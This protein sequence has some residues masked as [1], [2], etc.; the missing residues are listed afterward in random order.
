MPD[1]VILLHGLWLRAFTL[2]RLAQTLR[3]GGYAVEGF[4]YHSLSEAPACAVEKLA[5]RIGQTRGPVHLVGHSLGG[6]I[7]LSALGQHALPVPRAVCLGS[8]LC[9]SLVARRIGT[10]RGLRGVLGRARRLLAEGLERWEGATEVGVV[11][12]SRSLGF[13]VL[14]GR[15]QRPHDGTVAVA[16]TRLPG[17]RD[18]VIV[19]TTHS[20]LL[21]SPEAARQT[22]FFLRHGRFRHGDGVSTARAPA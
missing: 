9:G 5:E 6:L 19:D 21:F 17:I 11:A 2:A 13:G 10:V 22:L 1:T 14:A 3:A 7:A 18:H 20:G 4:D 15:I 16:E 8:P 12:G